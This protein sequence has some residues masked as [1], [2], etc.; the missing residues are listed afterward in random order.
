MSPC[1][2][3]GC[4]CICTCAWYCQWVPNPLP[5]APRR[6]LWAWILRLHKRR[7]RKTRWAVWN[8]TL[9]TILFPPLCHTLFKKTQPFVVFVLW[10][11]GLCL[12]WKNY[13]CLS[14]GGNWV[15]QRTFACF[16]FP[17]AVAVIPGVKNPFLF[18]QLGLEDLQGQ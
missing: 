12:I 9:S 2:C 17:W 8:I 3:G 6:L 7:S 1:A 13:V 10:S 18:W 16:C 11:V 14:W 5:S 4:L 15:Y